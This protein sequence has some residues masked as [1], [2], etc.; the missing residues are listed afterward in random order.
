MSDLSEIEMGD[1]S[2]LSKPLTK[3]IE[4]ISIG[5][6]KLYEPMHIKRM[7]KAKAFEIQTICDSISK[8]D[9]LPV[10][11]SDGQLLLMG[12]IILNL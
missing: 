1:F 2:G 7:A 12:E 3:L 11:Y 6:G 8:T 4:T 5:I 10:K 9:C